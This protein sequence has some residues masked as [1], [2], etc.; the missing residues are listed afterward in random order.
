MQHA[1]DSKQVAKKILEKKKYRISDTTW[2]D[3]KQRELK[4]L[5]Q[6][7]KIQEAVFSMIYYRHT[8]KKVLIT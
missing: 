1:E 4:I 2:K 5:E 3:I 8:G 7:Q 6:E